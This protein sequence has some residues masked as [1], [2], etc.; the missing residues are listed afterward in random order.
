M[1]EKEVEQKVS[2][3]EWLPAISLFCL[4]SPDSV[5]LFV[6]QLLDSDHDHF[7]SKKDLMTFLVQKRN[8][9]KIFYFNYMKA[10]ELLDIERPDKISIEQFRKIQTQIPFVCYPAFRLQKSLRNKIFGPKYWDVLYERILNK[11]N[12]ENKFKQQQKIQEEIRR[13]QQ[14]KI[15]KKV[16][17]FLQ[18]THLQHQPQPSLKYKNVRSHKRINSDTMVPS[19]VD[20]IE[21]FVQNVYQSFSKQLFMN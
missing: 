21:D 4:Y 13:K 18:N 17:K 19:T 9:K 15:D 2:F 16:E 5:V 8:N 10:V 1:I 20:K 3:S 14:S 7:I 12:D 6:F 11:E